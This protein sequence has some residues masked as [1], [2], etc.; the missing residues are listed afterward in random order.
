MRYQITIE[1]LNS[2]SAGGNQITWVLKRGEKPIGEYQT[3][4]EAEEKKKSLL[5]EA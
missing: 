3:K 2:Y 1:P 4:E 5:G